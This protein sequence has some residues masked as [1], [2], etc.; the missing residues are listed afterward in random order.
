MVSGVDAPLNVSEGYKLAGSAETLEVTSAHQKPGGQYN[1]DSYYVLEAHGAHYPATT[2][3]V[4][5]AV[6]PYPYD[7]PPV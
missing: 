2:F 5:V 3:L 1:P 7:Y 4:V 6:L